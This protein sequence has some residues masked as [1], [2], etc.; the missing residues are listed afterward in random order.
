MYLSQGGR[1]IYESLDE[2][3]AKGI[4]SAC[5]Y[6]GNYYISIK[7]SDPYHNSIWEV[8]KKTGKVSYKN[9]IRDFFATGICDKAKEIDPEIL[10][11]AN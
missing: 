4:T 9:L 6:D 8:N 2:L 7:S 1:E 10:K 3:I 11:R 5:E